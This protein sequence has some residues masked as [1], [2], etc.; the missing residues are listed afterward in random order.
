MRYAPHYPQT[1]VST[2]TQERIQAGMAAF[3]A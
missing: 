3:H 2:H 1:A